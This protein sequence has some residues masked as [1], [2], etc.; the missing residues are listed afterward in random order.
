VDE[1][2]AQFLELEMAPHFDK[3]FLQ[4]QPKF[5][6]VVKTID[7]EE[8]LEPFVLDLEKEDYTAYLQDRESKKGVR[9]EILGKS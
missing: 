4:N 8:I 9:E 2:T 7:S 6:A 1:E 3:D 5:Q